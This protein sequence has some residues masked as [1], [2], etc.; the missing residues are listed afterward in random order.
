MRGLYEPKGFDQAAQA[1]GVPW[2]HAFVPSIDEDEEG[3]M[4]LQL[5]R[6]D[7]DSKVYTDGS[8]QKDTNQTDVDV[9]TCQSTHCCWNP[10]DL[11]ELLAFVAGL[12][13]GLWPG[14]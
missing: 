1:P 6:Y 13:P 12:W 14:K 10:S 9:Y 4:R 11:C 2:G 3:S 7:P 5:K 8:Y